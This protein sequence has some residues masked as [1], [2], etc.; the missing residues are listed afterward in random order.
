MKTHTKDSSIRT[1]EKA[2]EK[3]IGDSQIEPTIDW[4]E[5]VTRKIRKEF[6]NLRYEDFLKALQNVLARIWEKHFQAIEEVFTKHIWYAINSPLSYFA[7]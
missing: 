4:L 1:I 5:G 7:N 6:I 2:I 3:S